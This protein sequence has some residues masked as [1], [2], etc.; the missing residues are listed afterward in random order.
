MHVAR[1]KKE[2]EHDRLEQIKKKIDKRIAARQVLSD[3]E[4][5][6]R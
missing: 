2:A 4:L 1:L 5:F 6:K 3:N